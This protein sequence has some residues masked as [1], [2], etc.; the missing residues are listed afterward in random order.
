MIRDGR[1][2]NSPET[3]VWI[4]MVLDLVKRLPARARRAQALASALGDVADNAP[5]PQRKYYIEA[6]RDR[7][8]GWLVEGLRE[9]AR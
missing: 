9:A 8:P 3:K 6:V 7:L 5:E 4:S 2:P 1:D